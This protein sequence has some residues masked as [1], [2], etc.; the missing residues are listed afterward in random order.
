MVCAYNGQRNGLTELADT[1]SLQTDEGIVSLRRVTLD[2]EPSRLQRG[3]Y[4]GRGAKPTGLV[5]DRTRL[6]AL[7]PHTLPNVLSKLPRRSHM[8][9]D[10]RLQMPRSCLPIIPRVADAVGAEDEFV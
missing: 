10:L 3:P 5:S 4:T 8:L 6:R 9:L 7:S 2:W 1:L